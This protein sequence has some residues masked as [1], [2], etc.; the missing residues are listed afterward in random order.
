VRSPGERTRLPAAMSSFDEIAGEV[1]AF[2][3]ATAADPAA[4]AG[5][6]QFGEL[7]LRAFDVQ[8][9]ANA[10]YRRFC[11]RRRVDPGSIR[12]WEDVPAVPT[13][14]FK[15]IDLACGPAERVFVTSG[16]TR[17]PARRGRHLVPRLD[18]YRSSALAHFRRMVLPDDAKLRLVAA[19]PGPDLLPQSSLTQMVE[20]IRTDTCGSR[21]EYLVDATGFE[22]A[23][24]A[25]RIAAAI[26]DGQPICLIGLRVLLTR[27]VEH[28]RLH[29]RVL[30]LPAD[31]RIVDTGG[32][33][34]GRA[35]SDAGFLAA[36]WHVFGVAG[37]DCVNEYGMT[38]LC[39]QF[40]DDSLRSR[41]DGSNAPRR[42]LG[43]PWTRTHAVDPESL[44][45]L[46]EGERGILCHFDL[47]N[48]GS[49]I[50]V[51]TED[52]GV[53]TGD[54]FRLL[55]R[56]PGAEPRGCALALADLLADTP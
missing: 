12:R 9:R 33:K 39:S 53:V 44:L 43:A 10:P 31:S 25:D 45:R 6:R 30:R 35:L 41:F 48:A 49:V 3:A 46:P 32:P 21:G 19:L 13:T 23:R 56:L 11:D 37:Y 2:I 40:Y 15:E 52:V 27:L 1:L 36:A 29:G 24:A 28:C 55:G 22:P 47:A 5:G 34:G 50:A 14:A 20:W 8:Y 16:T 18:I 26:A 38:E 4:D 7:A 42:K 17:G 51:Q 54:R